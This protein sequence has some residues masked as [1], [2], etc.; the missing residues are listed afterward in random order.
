M[1]FLSTV[2]GLVLFLG[3]PVF[4]IYK[5]YKLLS[6]T[7]SFNREQK[8]LLNKKR[9][10]LMDAQISKINEEILFYKREDTRVLNN[11]GNR[12]NKGGGYHDSNKNDSDR[13]AE[14]STR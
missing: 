14:Y 5:L 9:L 12:R 4:I 2:L 3:L 7:L 13:S 10:Q 6:A 1:N 8:E 11:T